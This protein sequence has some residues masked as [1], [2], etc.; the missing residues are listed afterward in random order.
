MIARNTKIQ[1]IDLPN[2]IIEI[3]ILCH[4]RIEN[5]RA[6]SKW[7]RLNSKMRTFILWNPALYFSISLE[8]SHQYQCLTDRTFTKFLNQLKFSGLVQ[9]IYLSG[10]Q[11]VTCDS[12]LLI[13]KLCR[14]LRVL[15]I[16]D[17]CKVDVLHLAKEI[18]NIKSPS[19]NQLQ[20][21][22]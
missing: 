19:A 8:S 14:N 15:D 20:T 7:I 21:I 12:I 1:L 17:C 16:Q 22:R 2:E 4:L 9:R 18:K 11:L 13:L 10:N 6:I 3:I 5:F